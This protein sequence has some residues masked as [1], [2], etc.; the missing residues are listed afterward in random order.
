MDKNTLFSEFGKW[1]SPIN[2][3]KF[4]IDLSAEEISELYRSHW[5]S[6]KLKKCCK[7][8][9]STF[10]IFRLRVILLLLLQIVP[11]QLFPER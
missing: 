4:M 3:Q 2:I 9:F 11:L 1:G 8:N 6:K 10:S 7:T 5:A